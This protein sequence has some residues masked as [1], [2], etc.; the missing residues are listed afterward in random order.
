[1]TLDAACQIET[2][3]N[4]L[5][6]RKTSNLDRQE[7]LF[8][9]KQLQKLANIVNSHHSN[10]NSYTYSNRKQL[11]NT[12]CKEKCIIVVHKHLYKE[13]LNLK[14]FD[15][16]KKRLELLYFLL[17]FRLE[18]EKY[19]VLKITFVNKLL[20]KSWSKVSVTLTGNQP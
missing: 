8:G 17:F 5:K 12:K 10:I 2:D 4:K 19:I 13:C 16:R 18:N 20:L 9:M 11:F 3:Y 15:N 1:M 14:L 7:G 6:I